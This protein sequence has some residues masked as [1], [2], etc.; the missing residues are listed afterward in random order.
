MTHEHY[1]F[2]DILCYAERIL[3]HPRALSPYAREIIMTIIII[4][5][6]VCVHVYF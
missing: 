5:L 1:V 6:C 2:I 3:V 4:G